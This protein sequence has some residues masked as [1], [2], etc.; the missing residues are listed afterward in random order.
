MTRQWSPQDSFSVQLADM[1]G[2]QIAAGAC[3]GRMTVSLAS[4]VVHVDPSRPNGQGV[5]PTVGHPGSQLCRRAARAFTLSMICLM[6]TSN[7]P[8]IRFGAGTRIFVLAAAL[9]SVAILGTAP[10]HAVTEEVPS[11]TQN[12]CTLLP[13]WPGCPRT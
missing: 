6:A 3:G 4:W 8:R 13:F 2:R 5:R 1:S 11:G 7:H 12:I 10:S 9:V